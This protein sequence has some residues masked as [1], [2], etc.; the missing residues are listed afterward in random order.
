[1]GSNNKVTTIALAT[2]NRGKI[3]EIRIGL[4]GTRVEVKAVDD[5]PD[6]PEVEETESTLT[7]NAALK[8]EALFA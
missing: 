4:A 8:S 1:M 6:F 7:G 2:R 5:Y 3:E